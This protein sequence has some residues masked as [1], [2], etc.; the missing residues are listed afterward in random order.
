MKE[1]RGQIR[2]GDI[3]EGHTGWFEIKVGIYS[4]INTALGC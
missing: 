2:G 1:F 4:V 3:R